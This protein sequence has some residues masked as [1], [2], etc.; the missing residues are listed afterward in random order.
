M[1]EHTTCPP[2]RTVAA[3]GNNP[4]ADFHGTEKVPK[5]HPTP[6]PNEM[7]EG[8]VTLLTCLVRRDGI[9]Y[10]LGR[11]PSTVSSSALAR[12]IYPASKSELRPDRAAKS[13][14]LCSNH[15]LHWRVELSHLLTGLNDSGSFSQIRQK[16]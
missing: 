3:E 14:S 16:A 13:F 2:F 5:H 7:P 12:D 6:L 4:V 10:G 9:S 1:F 15:C 11:V 8:N